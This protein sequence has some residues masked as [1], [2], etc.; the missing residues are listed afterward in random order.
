M[1]CTITPIRNA[2]VMLTNQCNLGCVY[3]YQQ[4]RPERMTFEMAKDV[5]RFLHT[6]DSPR[7]GFTLFG[8]EPMLEYDSI[9]YPLIEWSKEDPNNAV[10]F[11]MTSNG[12]LFTEE[13]L[14]FLKD[15][16][17]NFMLSMDGNATAQAGNRPMKNG[18][19]SFDVV[20]KYV[21]LILELWP[22]QSF[23]STI[24]PESAKNV[25]EDILFFEKIGCQNLM[26]LPDQFQIWS[27][28]AKAALRK[29]MELYEQYI[30][31]K[32][33][34][35]EVP[36]LLQDIVVGWRSISILMQRANLPRRSNPTC[37]T[38]KQCGIGVKGSVSITPTGDIYGCHHIT[39]LMHD[40]L[41]YLG[42]IY[43]GIDEARVQQ[44][45]AMH[46]PQKMGG[47][48]CATC[49]L[50]KICDGGCIPNNYQI[51]GDFHAVPE[52]Y[53]E[54]KRMTTDVA[55]RLLHKLENNVLFRQTLPVRMNRGW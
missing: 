26:M 21:P 42:D 53:C 11:A 4:R 13:R 28:E 10:R 20:M 37:A 45:A 50:D 36:L 16:G 12:T 3:C 17:V 32:F 54:W 31:E 23:R 14:R 52:M 22:N 30:C 29:Q 41:F 46:D 9:I 40:S 5:V 34:R 8:G 7:P 2:I 48:A 18:G 55:F 33:E 49:G 51:N 27:P 1:S 25:F 44:L 24:T 19:N 15:N 38:C 6:G 39:P 47:A 43:S 35:N